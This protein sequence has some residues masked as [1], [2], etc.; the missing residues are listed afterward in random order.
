MGKL[1]TKLI[2]IF[3]LLIVDPCQKITEML[4][5]RLKEE[6]LNSKNLQDKLDAQFEITASLE[7]EIDDMNVEMSKHETLPQKEN[8][9]IG[10]GSSIKVIQFF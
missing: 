5:N 7:K 3:F 1:G 10:K 4:T 6:F 8:E 9:N 2:F